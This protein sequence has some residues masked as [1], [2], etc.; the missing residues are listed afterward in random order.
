VDVD[1]DQLSAIGTYKPAQALVAKAQS[2]VTEAGATLLSDRQSLQ[3]ATGA[4]A[5][6]TQAKST[7]DSKLRTLALA[8][9][10]GVGYSI[11]GSGSDASPGSSPANTT[12]GL[13]GMDAVDAQ[14][15]LV[16][17]GQHAR[18][19]DNGAARTLVQATNSVK[20]ATNLYKHDQNVVN[21]SEAQ[22]LAAQQTLKLVTTAAITPGAAAATP[23]SDLMSY[24]QSG[25]QKQ[26]PA[27][28][29]TTSST[30]VAPSSTSSTVTGTLTPALQEAT[31]DIPNPV[32]P[33]I[34]GKP[35]LNADQLLA[36]WNTLNRKP[37]ITVPI[38]D[39][40][41]SY[42]KW[43]AR[44]GVRYDVAFAQSIV[45][46][47]SFSFPSFGQ[48]TDKDNNFA[49]IGA[50]DTCAK[51]WSFPSA[52]TG[53]LAQLELLREYATNDPLPKGIP[54]VIGGTGVGGC[55]QSWTQLAGKWASSTVYGISIMTV[56]QQELAWLIP[57]NEVSAGLIAPTSPAAKGPDLAPLPGS[58][59][60]PNQA[61]NKAAAGA[62]KTSGPTTTSTTVPQSV[63]AAGTKH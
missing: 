61:A 19:A 6:A 51:G 30:T 48:L 13:T 33:A 60:P 52:D 25:G 58:K 10:M 27:T 49:G 63:T 39:L 37:N 17:V 44:L 22:L 41:G 8:A 15:M 55:C 43:G 5:K 3:R 34:M 32:A 4:A 20:A 40:I 7:A 28:T 31:A 47:G 42:A 45:E 21:A 16:V 50:C 53:V 59:P 24:I 62:G 12:G 54:N 57:Q 26:P 18:Q 11:P 14:E 23:L 56:Y 2:K 9:Y 46:T 1:L 35:Q 36:W 29:T 38:K